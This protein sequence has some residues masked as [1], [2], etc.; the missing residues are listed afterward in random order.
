M[1]FSYIYID[2]HVGLLILRLSPSYVLNT[3]NDPSLYLA[4]SSIK[5]YELYV[6]LTSV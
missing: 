4:S 3:L 2:F 1:E 6:F 5:P